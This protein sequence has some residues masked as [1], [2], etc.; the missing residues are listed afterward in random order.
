MNSIHRLEN[1][2]HRVRATIGGAASYSEES[3]WSGGF[4][5]LIDLKAYIDP[6]RYRT[7]VLGSR[8]DQ[9]AAP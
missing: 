7:T 4:V 6:P 3:T 9:G 8:S 1:R 5:R 2:H